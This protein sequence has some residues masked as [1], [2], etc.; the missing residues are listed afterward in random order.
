L[1]CPTSCASKVISA[2]SSKGWRRTTCGS[3]CLQ[4]QFDTKFSQAGD[5][6]PRRRRGG[7]QSF[8]EC[9]GPDRKVRLAVTYL[10][11]E[12]GFCALKRHTRVSSKGL[13]AALAP[14]R[15]ERL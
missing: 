2:I 4:V 7:S 5:A 3:P 8:F 10:Q 9:D 13:R 15:R 11:H 6:R 14:D 12:L 1:P